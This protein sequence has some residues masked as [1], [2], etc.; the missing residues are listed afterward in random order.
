MILYLN[1]QQV[2][3]NADTVIA[4][5]KQVNDLATL[6]NR[7]NNF[8]N[9][10]KLP[11]TSANKKIFQFMGETGSTSMLPYEK[12]KVSLYAD[13]GECFVYK[14]WAL[15]SDEGDYFEVSIID[16]I[17]DF[18]KEIENKALSDLV[19]T[20]LVHTKDVPTVIASW[21]DDT[22][23]YR[24]ILA[25]YN[26]NTGNTNPIP[27]GGLPQVNIDYLVPSVNV[28]WLWD[29]IMETFHVNY[30]GAVFQ[31]FNFKNLWL[32]FPKGLGSTGEND[33][34][35]F[36]SDNYSFSPVPGSGTLG[37]LA[38]VSN[39]ST[40]NELESIPEGKYM[41]VA[42][43]ATY[44]LEIKATLYGRFLE[45]IVPAKIWV[46]K[47]AE[48]N[49]QNATLNPVL[50]QGNNPIFGTTADAIP[51]G[52]ETE[53]ISDPFQLNEHES[54]LI[55]INGN[56]ASFGLYPSD[57]NE[58]DVRLV[59]VDAN[60]INFGAAFTD[61]GIKEFVNE[62]I[63][64]FGLTLFKDKYSNNYE[65]LTLREVLQNS[66][67]YNWSDK[68]HGDKRESYSFGTYAQRN[69]LRYA[70]NDKEA[71]HNDAFIAVS[72]VNLSDSKDVIKSKIYSPEKYPSVYLGA[73]TNIYKLWDK[74]PKEDG[75]INY[76]AL[77]KRYY[78]LRANAETNDIEVRSEDMNITTPASSYYRESFYKLSFT[79][80]KADYYDPLQRI[81]DRTQIVRAK[82]WLKDTDIV[83]IDFK[84]LVYVEQL[85]NYYLINK[86]ENYIPG[87]A[88]TVELVRVMYS[89]AP[90]TAMTLNI[91]QIS[92]LA[93]EGGQ[94]LVVMPFLSSYTTATLIVERSLDNITWSSV[95]SVFAFNGV[96]CQVSDYVG[97][98]LNYFRI[99]DIDN[100]VISNTPSII[101]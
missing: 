72:N 83:N 85:S 96:F 9:L 23:P 98:G 43:T 79:D 33:H 69:F 1:D 44:R 52:V 5:T 15:A 76:K 51:H 75:T 29:K 88:T 3:Q 7:N 27:G 16:G 14:G 21:N 10:I 61:F 38:A 70:Y 45:T 6:S 66:E 64:R 77:D 49:P 87:R 60:V 36:K 94:T 91:T 30:S 48:S 57:D 90:Q 39:S 50:T 2:E 101:L 26:G 65:F 82:F 34:D 31:M 18:F 4:Q 73:N 53:L 8:T 19:L 40:V 78:F 81:L 62:I 35:I 13:S 56:G 11:K 67:V 20:D 95:E 41:K 89:D 63:Q 32:T 42:E 24:Y 47:N 92:K 22:L 97:T 59:R 28:K 71:S 25:D 80:I 84:K 68:Y 99:Q 55:A 12:V 54:I 100:S 86:I 17:K 93:G 37:Y 58:L 46:C 74:E